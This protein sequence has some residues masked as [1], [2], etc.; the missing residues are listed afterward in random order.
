MAMAA[1]AATSPHKVLAALHMVVVVV[2]EVN[3]L[4]AWLAQQV[5]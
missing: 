2:V 1:A 4:M 3:W 5:L